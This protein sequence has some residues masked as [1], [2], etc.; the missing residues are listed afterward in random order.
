MSNN[1]RLFVIHYCNDKQVLH[2]LNKQIN[3][4]TKQ[5]TKKYT[6]TSRQTK[7]ELN[8]Q[9]NT[10]LNR[11]TN[12]ELNRQTNNRQTDHQTNRQIDK[13]QRIYKQKTSWHRLRDENFIHLTNCF[14]H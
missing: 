6:L 1:L 9:T 3:K 10:E 11:Q 13:K 8:R 7:I 12:T 2:F 4:K 14:H 5:K